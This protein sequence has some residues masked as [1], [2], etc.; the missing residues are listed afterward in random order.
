VDEQ[1]AEAGEQGGVMGSLRELG[2]SV[3]DGITGVVRRP[4]DAASEGGVAAVAG[5]VARGLAGLIAKPLSG[6]ASFVSR[7]LKMASRRVV[8][9]RGSEVAVDGR[10]LGPSLPRPEDALWRW[11]VESHSRVLAGPSLR[12]SERAWVPMLCRWIVSSGLEAEVDECIQSQCE[13]SEDWCVWWAWSARMRQMSGSLLDEPRREDC[14]VGLIRSAFTGE[15]LGLL[16]TTFPWEGDHE[17]SYFFV[18]RRSGRGG[19]FWSDSVEVG[20]GLCLGVSDGHVLLELES[21]EGLPR[22]LYHGV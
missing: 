10:V 15:V 2:S 11:F 6:A 18:P 1:M 9:E 20:S 13:G 7:T 22:G 4:L 3:L 19:S 5:G 12:A 21:R 17:A 8:R 16:V 14:V